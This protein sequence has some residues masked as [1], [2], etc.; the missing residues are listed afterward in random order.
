[1]AIVERNIKYAWYIEEFKTLA[2]V[3][4]IFFEAKAMQ[5][6]QLFPTSPINICIHILL[7]GDLRCG[8]YGNRSIKAAE[9]FT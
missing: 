8:L 6:D 5:W 7:S 2:L 3:L 9:R 1:M 4:V